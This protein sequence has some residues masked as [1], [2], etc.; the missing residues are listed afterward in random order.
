[1]GGT[2]LSM[3]HIREAHL[4]KL[5]SNSGRETRGCSRSQHQK[6]EDRPELASINTRYEGLGHVCAPELQQTRARRKQG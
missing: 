3:V 5:W 6:R 2:H 4:S 1:M